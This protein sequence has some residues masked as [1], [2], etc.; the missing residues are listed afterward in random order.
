MDSNMPV[1]TYISIALSIFCILICVI[2]YI[3]LFI[4]KERRSKLTRIFGIVVLF[5]IGIISSDIL[6]YA[7]EGNTEPYTYYLIRAANFFHYAFGSLIMAGMTFYIFANLEIKVKVPRRLKDTVLSL[8]A[9]SLILIVVSQ[10]T[11]IYYYIDEHNIYHRGEVFWLSQ[12]LPIVG[13]LLNIVIVFYY[14]KAFVRYFLF[15]FIA[16]MLLPMAAL[17]MAMIYYGITFINIGTTLSVF[18]LFIG[19]QI[20]HSYNMAMRLQV[21]DVQLELQGDHY[22]S[23]REHIDETKRNRHDLRQHLSVFQTFIDTGD[24]DNLA[25]YI[26]EYQSSLPEEEVITF[27]DNYAVNSILYYYF[28]ISKE[29]EI[30]ITINTQVPE[31]TGVS[32]TDLCIIFGNCIE[33]AIEACRK[34]TGERFISINSKITG[35]M[36]FITIDNSFSGEVQKKDDVFLTSKQTGGGIGI[37][38]VKTVALKHNGLALFEPKDGKFRVSVMLQLDIEPA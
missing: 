6:A 12:V 15:F 8:C 37:T 18:I 29:E 4:D 7:I 10:F 17:C 11:G 1:T 38:S 25:G 21:L 9:L 20:E 33:N 13:M 3:C 34:M 24:T 23:L 22:K 32:D 2:I 5:N 19:V 14:R 31:E 28:T 27:C 16:Y 30:D 35:D 36:L 26:N